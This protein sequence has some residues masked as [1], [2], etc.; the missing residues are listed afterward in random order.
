M[1]LQRS[2]FRSA[3]ETDM[4]RN[5]EDG[6]ANLTALR[7]VGSKAERSRPG[8]VCAR[9]TRQKKESQGGE[10]EEDKKCKS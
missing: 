7:T 1:L 4:E 2:R 5:L 9:P 3:L 6:E 8:D 10:K